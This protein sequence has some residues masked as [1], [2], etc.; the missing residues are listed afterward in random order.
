M[1]S[2][3]N[4]KKTGISSSIRNITSFAIAI[5]LGL[6]ILF[7][8][9]NFYNIFNLP[10]YLGEFV[11]F[12]LLSLILVFL[13]SAYIQ[14]LSCSKI[15]WLNLFKYIIPTPFIQIS[16]W[17]LLY[18]F[19]I[20]RWPIE[21]LIQEQTPELRKGVSSAFYGFWMG[22]YTQSLMNAFAQSCSAL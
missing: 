22:L 8:N 6:T 15:N 9:S 1:S 11:V 13:A 17:A 16:I 2:S 12:P 3:E 10:M 19:P 14:Y 4:L 5:I 18:M 21:G 7:W 20:L